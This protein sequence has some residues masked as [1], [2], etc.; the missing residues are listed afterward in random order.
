LLLEYDL[1]IVGEMTLRI[2]H[3][4]VGHSGSGVEKIRRVYSHPQVF[5]Q[6]KE[7]L[8]DYP[9][10]DLVACKDTATGVRRVKENGDPEEAA[11]A[12]KEAAEIH[13]MTLLQQG[14]ETNPR[15]FTRFVVISAGNFLDGPKNKSSLIY[16]VSDQ[17]GS[18]YETL[19]ILAERRINLVKLESRP[20][21]SKP[22]EYLFYAD[23]EVDIQ[24]EQYRSLL[25]D[26]QKKTEFLKILGSY[27]KGVDSSEK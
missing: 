2:E 23:I 22:W 26:L 7:F 16:S 20:I 18:L 8:E 4:L 13:G 15:N 24:D 6:C 10:W 25:E 19:K 27:P 21:H 5:Q 1:H 3:N 9:D 12:G 17:P 11:I 14:I